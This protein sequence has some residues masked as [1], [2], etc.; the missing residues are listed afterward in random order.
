M[1]VAFYPVAVQIKQASLY[2]KF[3]FQMLKSIEDLII[4]IRMTIAGCV[5]DPVAIQIKQAMI[6]YTSAPVPVS[7]SPTHS[8]MTYFQESYKYHIFM[9]GQNIRQTITMNSE[10]HS[11]L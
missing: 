4:P 1:L 5:T 2:A 9:N 10:G 11:K 3:N 8:L 7:L 6:C